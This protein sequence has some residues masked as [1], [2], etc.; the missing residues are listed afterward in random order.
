LT[1]TVAKYCWSLIA[2]LRRTAGRSSTT[3]L[4]CNAGWLLDHLIQSTTEHAP[5]ARSNMHFTKAIRSGAAEDSADEAMS[6]VP[7]RGHICQP[8]KYLVVD[9]PDPQASE[10]QARRGNLR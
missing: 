1:P 6:E 7:H 10:G 4:K 9:L 5:N 3:G 8:T 2:L